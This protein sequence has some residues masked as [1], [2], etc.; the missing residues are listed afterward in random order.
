MMAFI[1]DY[2]Y[3]AGKRLHIKIGVH[4]GSCIFGV[5]GYHK[6]QFSLIG[7]TINTTSRHC[8]TG[9]KGRIILSEACYQ[10]VKTLGICKIKKLKVAMKGKGDDIAIYV[11]RRKNWKVTQKP[12]DKLTSNHQM[13]LESQASSRR[14]S[15]QAD[16]LKNFERSSNRQPSLLLEDKS[17]VEESEAHESSRIENGYGRSFANL[18]DVEFMVEPSAQSLNSDQKEAEDADSQ[19]KKQSENQGKSKTTEE[20]VA[21]GD[22]D[23]QEVLNPAK[24]TIFYEEK[25]FRNYDHYLNWGLIYS[26]FDLS[27]AEILYWADPNMPVK[28]A[29]FRICYIAIILLY[30]IFLIIKQLRRNTVA[31][32]FYLMVVIVCRHML[33]CIEYIVTHYQYGHSPAHYY[34]LMYLAMSKL[35]GSA[36]D[37]LCICSSGIFLWKQILYLSVYIASLHVLC[38]C[39]HQVPSYQYF[40]LVILMGMT[41][42]LL[43]SWRICHKQL[44]SFFRIVSAK[45]KSVYLS[46][47]VDRLLPK[48]VRFDAKIRF[49]K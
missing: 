3:K 4:Y 29:A 23:K 2:T 47:F 38:Q 33:C 10:E 27:I 46:K 44:E 11:I 24:P 25:L 8:T 18:D 6:P 45:K 42:N 36:C 35:Y 32:K 15:V 40:I 17:F 28:N 7:D 13:F 14:M 30:V 9:D 34:Q 12:E 41:Y 31:F 39:V 1:E 20:D 21:K 22:S 43:A 26:V 49:R 16:A 5:L 19:E 48:H 37:M